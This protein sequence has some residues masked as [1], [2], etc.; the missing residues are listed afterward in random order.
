M[1]HKIDWRPW[2]A[3][4][5]RISVTWRMRGR[6]T[7]TLMT[8]QKRPTNDNEDK[9]HFSALNS[10]PVLSTKNFKSYLNLPDIP[11]NLLMEMLSTTDIRRLTQVSNSWKK[12]ITENFLNISANQKTL[13]ATA[14]ATA[15]G[16]SR[17]EFNIFGYLIL[18][19]WM[20][21][22]NEEITNFIWLSK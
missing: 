7:L 12:K 8:S 20:P 21:P 5:I 6:R 15:R 4:R 11:F 3:I 22:S 2:A 14:T 13:K 18:D 17:K 10:N 9:T 16:W 19:H 1:R